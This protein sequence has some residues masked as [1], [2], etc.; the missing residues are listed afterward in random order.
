LA[1]FGRR[2]SVNA[3]RLYRLVRKVEAAVHR[4]DLVNTA[5]KASAV[6]K[7]SILIVERLLTNSDK[8]LIDLVEQ[9][10]P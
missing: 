7:K 3:A 6:N 5:P 4:W 1:G 9:L 2:W 10:T 8:E